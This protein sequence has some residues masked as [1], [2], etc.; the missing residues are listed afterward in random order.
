MGSQ[1]EGKMGEVLLTHQQNTSFFDQLIFN[2]SE[3]KPRKSGGLE[4]SG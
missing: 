1:I 2:F 4:I 3:F